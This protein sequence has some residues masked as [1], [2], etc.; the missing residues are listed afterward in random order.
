MSLYAE[1]PKREFRATWLTT[2]WAIDWPKSTN[3]TTQKSELTTILDNLVAANMNAVCFQIRGLGDVMYQSDLE[4]WNKVLTGTRGKNPG[5]DPLAFAIE[6]AHKR[7]L[8]LHAWMNPFR[9]ESTSGSHGSSDPVRKNHPDWLLTYNNGSFSGTIFDPGLPEVR[10]YVVKVVKEVVDNYDIDGVIFD[11]YFYPYGGTTSEDAVSKAAYKP[12]NM[13]D[14]EWRCENID[15]TMKGVYDMIAA[16]K[17]PWVR[18][19]ISPF[20]TWTTQSS[21]ARKYGISLPSGITSMDAYEDLACNTI[22]W[23]QGG[24]VD[25]ISP[26]LYWPTTSSGQSYITLSKWWSDMAKHFSDLLPGDQKVHFFSSQSPSSNASNSEQGKEIDY[27]RQYDQLGAPGSI[28]YNTSAFVSTGLPSYLPANKYTDDALPPAMDWKETPTLAAPTN[29]TLSGT[30]LSWSH[31]SAERFTVY[32]YTK[33]LDNAEAMADPS[34]LVQVVYGKSLNVSSVSGYTNKTFAVCAYDRYGNEYNAG[35]YNLLVAEP[36][37]IA[38]PTSFELTAKQNQTAPAIDIMIEGFNLTSAMSVNSSTNS[39]SVS[40]LSGWNDLTGGTLRATLSTD[41]ILNK[42]GYIAIQSGTTTKITIPFTI[43]VK[44]LAPSITV[45]PSLVSLTGMQ[46]STFSPHKDI[47]VV[48]E[49]LS[50]DIVITST[51]VVSCTPLSG[52]DARTG[53]TLRLTLNT[54]QTLGKHTGSVTLTSGTITQTIAINTTITDA[55]QDGKVTISTQWTKTNP[56]YIPSSGD[57][58]RSIAY[59]DNKLY[60][61]VYSDMQFHIVDAA[62]GNLSSTKKLGVSSKYHSF[63]LR[64]AADGQLLSGNNAIGDEAFKIYAVDKVNGGSVEHTTNVSGSDRSDYFDVYG[65]WNESGYI[66][67]YSNTGTATYIPFANGALQTNNARTLGI[68]SGGISA[69]AIACDETSFYAHAHNAI[70]Q[71]YSITTGEILESFGSDAPATN[72]ATSGMAI[73]TIAG[74]KYMITPANSTGA[75]DVFEITEGLTNAKRVIETTASIGAN[76]NSSY[77]VDFATHVDG[78]DAYIYVLAP[79]NGV[80]AHK[81][82][83]T[84]NTPQITI[85]NTSVSV[86]GKV[87]QSPAPYVDVTIAGSNLSSA[88][89]VSSTGSG[90]KVE[91]VSG[92]GDLAGGRL[93]ITLDTS[94]AAKTYTGM[95]TVTSGTV[96]KTINITATVN[97]L[98]PAIT[99]GTSIVAITSKQDAAI[100][101]YKDVTVTAEDLSE[102][103]SIAASSDLVSVTKNAGWNDLTGG[104]I[105]I[106]LNPAQALGDHTCTVIVKSGTISKTITVNAAITDLE[107]RLFSSATAISLWGETGGDAPFQDIKITGVDL[108]DNI[109]IASTAGSTVTISKQSDWN[110]LTGGTLR[111][112]LATTSTSTYSGTITISSGIA[113]IAIPFTGKVTAPQT[114]WMTRYIVVSSPAVSLTTTVGVDT[115]VDVVVDAINFDSRTSLSVSDDMAIVTPEIQSDWSTRYGGTLRIKIDASTVGTYTGTITVQASRGGPWGT[116]SATIAVTVTISDVNTEITASTSSISLSGEQYSTTDYEDVSIRV[117]DGVSNL[118]ITTDAPVTVEPQG[119]WNALTGGTLRI[120]L[121]TNNEIGTYTGSVIVQ[122]G[123]TSVVINVHADILAPAVKEGS[124][125]FDPNALWTQ[126]P[127]TLSCL[128]TASNNRSMALYNGQLYISDKGAG[129]YHIVDAATG[130]FVRTVSVG[131]TDFEQHNLRITK[132]GQML[133]GNTGSGSS[134]SA[135]V[136]VRSWNMTTNALTELT[137]E[138]L[139]GRS[140]FF[141]PYGEWKKSGFLLALANSGALMKI[142]Y[143]NGALSSSQRLTA[144]SLQ[145]EPD[146]ALPKSAKAIPAS[147]TAFYSTATYNIPVKYSIDGSEILDEFGYDQPA[148]I[149]ASGLG[150]FSIHG[151]NYMITPANAKGGFDIF[152]ITNGLSSATRVIT[153]VSALGSNDNAA[154]TIE[155]CTRLD[156]DDVYIYEL[157]PNNSL[158]AY[159][160]TFTPK[161]LTTQVEHVENNVQILPTL[162]GVQLFFEGTEQVAIYAVNGVMV[163]NS[164]ATN[165]YACDLQTGVYM[166]RIGDQAY[167]FIK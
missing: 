10:D 127:S 158:R 25:Y 4:P 128:S 68:G 167:K 22:S 74:H 105:R 140:D 45:N 54:A 104:S 113:S 19:G 163:T 162:S 161:T 146:G 131:N 70:P 101:P 26:Q 36:T 71:K 79:N 124:I 147:S 32:A 106:T 53:G 77:T 138:T 110:D 76:S 119:D 160:F 154:M 86:S 152:D 130:N 116:P 114:G 111:V 42:E 37:I 49:D 155:Y 93:R 44:E 118:T 51:G 83:F 129:A 159:K 126:T 7:G 38:N 102:N 65:N 109:T 145:S 87:N 28:Y 142:P 27:N 56:T 132:D 166:I 31:A 57:K 13:T 24:Y 122:S 59:Y 34:N 157:A 96:V 98:Q 123:A 80:A 46:Y 89:S 143:A 136:A 8:E 115:Y 134:S 95:V 33:G 48:A 112:S 23:M 92:W 139:G 55:P 69:K 15:K 62:T 2:V 97:P 121:D 88:I 17:R 1:S 148:S 72:I 150:L 90:F 35:F 47:S 137:A 91:K 84:P 108:A 73:F 156:G 135:A 165:Y 120:Y 6:E 29:V 151:H 149:A 14:T 50:A 16:S 30:T 164:T 12:S 3:V 78:N 9:Y 103:L 11:D 63:N 100:A 58:N 133:F 21:V 43:V 5:Y 67:S 64:M 117:T 52:W 125:T 18:F 82:T 141:Y 20:G 94:L 144:V 81:F 41:E 66:I 60:I 107:P 99:L 85:S 153:P 75:F 61:P 40:K 39:V